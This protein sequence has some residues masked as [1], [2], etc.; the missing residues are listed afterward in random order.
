M[1]NNSENANL[2]ELT[3]PQKSIFLTD[4]FYGDEHI[5]VISGYCIIKENIDYSMLNKAINKLVENNDAYRI[6]FKEVDSS[7]KQ[8]FK[9]YSFTEF[10]ILNLKNLD[11][12]RNYL[13]NMTFNVFDDSPV[14]NAMFKLEDGTGGFLCSIHHSISDAWSMSFLIES[15]LKYYYSIKNNILNEEERTFSY[16]D[17]INS[18]NEYLSSNKYIKDKEYWENVF[19]TPV[20][21]LDIKKGATAF[22]T[23]SIRKSFDVPQNINEYCTLKKISPFSL[24]F[25]SISLY[26]SRIYNL[27]EITIGTPVLNRTNFKEKNTSGM[28]IATL[29]FRQKVDENISVSEFISQIAVNQIGLLRHQKY[30][31]SKIQDY[32]SQKFARSTNLYDIL[33]SYQNARTKNDNIDFES[34]W[35][36]TGHQSEALAINI[37]DIDNTGTLSINYDY[38]EKLFKDYEITDIH[39][40][41]LS[42]I[43]QIIENPDK[44]LK[45]IDIVTKDE[46]EI[47]IHKFNNTASAYDKNMTISK[48]FEEASKKHSK[49]I[50]LIYDDEILTYSELNK[51]ANALANI[52]KE[53][54]IKNNDVVGLM[55]YRSFEM[56]IAQLAVLKL[57]AAYLP[58]DPVYP[59]DRIDY[60]VSD[61]KCSYL[62]KTNSISFENGNIKIHNIFADELNKNTDFKNMSTPDDLA[63]IIYT[64]GSTGRPKGVMIQNKNII[65]TLIWR[66]NLYKFNK[67]TT[68][69]QIPSFSFDSS[70]E[71]IFT[72]LISGS[73][74]ILLKQNNTNFNLPLMQELIEK[75]KPNNMLVVPSFYNVLL[76]EIPEKLKAFNHIIVAG[77]GFSEELVSKH[78][79]LLPNVD[80][81]NEYGPTENS[82]CST[83]YKFDA[84]DNTVL[85][86]KPI[87]NCKCYVLNEN[88]KLQPFNIKGELYVS[89]PGVSSGYIGRDD[90]NKQRFIKNPFSGNSIMYKTGDIVTINKDGNLAFVER[91]DYQVKYNGYRINLGEIES[92][93]SKFIK[94][95]NVIT[96]IRKEEE[97]SI[98]SAF[99]ETT[100]DIDVSNLK[101]DLKKVLTHY[102]IPKDIILLDKF[103]ITP[104]GKIDRKAL[105][106]YVSTKKE[107]KDITKPRN[108]LDEKILNIWKNI[109]KQ[110][111]IGIDDN[112]FDIGGDSLSII[113]IQ[114]SLFKENIKVRSQDL[115][116]NPTVRL[117]TDKIINNDDAKN[118]SNKIFER[119]YKDD[120]N[121]ITKLTFSPKSVLLTGV[122]GFL[123]AHI[124]SEL[125]NN[126]PNINI[127]CLI[128]SKPNK[129]YI[130][131]LKEILHFYFEDKYD[132]LI[133]NRIFPIEGDLAREH[134][135][136]DITGYKLLL[137]EVDS[138]INCASLVKHFGV[139]DLFYNS[140]VLSVKNLIDFAKASNAT[141]N[142]ISTT[143]VSGNFLV[144]NDIEYDYT[145]NDF[146]IGQNYE[147]N[148]YVR[149]KFEAEALIYQEQ[150]NGLNANVFRVG[151]IMPRISDGKFQINKMDNAYYKRIDGF[152]KLKFLPDNLKNQPLE[153]TP[154]DSCA[155]AIVKLLAY[156]NKVFHLLNHNTIDI[157][158]LLKVAKKQ[159]KKI[160][161]VD[162]K[163]FSEYI[164]SLNDNTLLDSFITD[165]DDKKRLNYET[166]I[167][168][169]SDITN[170][171]LQVLGFRWPTIT[172][173]YLDTFLKI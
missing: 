64:S 130:E 82:V 163:Y 13:K 105:E 157:S 8:Y 44:L 104:N 66:K 117:I 162:S 37:C 155:K 94:N 108:E 46:K 40:R 88:L 21:Y 23:K 71:D 4:Q 133:N 76:N 154:V 79:K 14:K 52:L 86:G 132:L 74:L 30:P 102:M 53:N 129:N 47:L 122:T 146:Y 7:V 159:K 2:Y 12:L 141:L 165:L 18:E 148:V 116:E 172:E 103:P 121:N 59:K 49:N 169:N 67:E 61:S 80:L 167:I 1:I 144:K 99:I 70:V 28:F 114:S 164:H 145:E 156:N 27:K 96:L 93:I 171:Y 142:H 45:D 17:F 173:E 149:T 110:D 120:I 16:I 65:N 34:E 25:A 68:V 95:P 135:G 131:R 152:L 100:E 134:L 84:I 85:I 31:Y 5:S 3:Y 24:F 166:N 112:I 73:K 78:F 11:E 41:I 19:D 136:M 54:G 118:S 97:H 33:F 29:P 128:R 107:K 137:S 151:N 160:K 126:Y 39:N 115:F 92:V 89:G 101:H 140:N 143:S 36:F 147:D 90:L 138:I 56:I 9:E 15:V 123:G 62:L 57:G 35:I 63:Y 48:L 158:L 124:L 125:L 98:L 150:R 139:Y 6:C 38:L 127:Y 43:E 161:F 81:Y 91:A 51:K 106:N 119:L 60:M 111:N 58:I 72:P 83:Y 10:E 87:S 113:S 26:F 22:D 109:L 153:F 77:E 42:I 170:K 32:Y 75:Y 168:I 20:D 55:F 69:L 50:A